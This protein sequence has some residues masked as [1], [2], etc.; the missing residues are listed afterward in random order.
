MKDIKKYKL[1]ESKVFFGKTF[2]RVVALTSFIGVDVGDIGGWIESEENLS[3]YGNAWV[4]GNAKVH[5]NARV[6]GDARIHGNAFVH[7]NALVYGNAR[8]HGNALVYDDAFVYGDARVYDDARVYGDAW[9]N[10]DARIH[11][12]ARVYG[13]AWVNGS[14]RVYGDALVYGNAWVYGDARV[15]GDAVSTKYVNNIK[16]G[17]Y[18]ISISDNFICIG[19]KNYTII[20]WNNFSDDEIRAMDECALEWWKIWK[21]IIMGI[22]EA[23]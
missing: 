18:D 19:C 15:Y 13:N 6:Y 2:F 23:Y 21:P 12:N 5:G 9:V 4:Y 14:A 1:G 3:H 8:I 11:G 10:G 17:V 22:I 7:G 16:S 20:D